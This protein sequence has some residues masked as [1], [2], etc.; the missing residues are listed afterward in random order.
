MYKKFHLENDINLISHHD[1]SAQTGQDIPHTPTYSR[2]SKVRS[3]LTRLNHQPKKFK[4]HQEF[5]HSDLKV[6]EY[7][8]KT[9]SVKNQTLR[10]LNIASEVVT[11]TKRLMPYGAGNQLFNIVST[12]GES[13]IRSY[14]SSYLF[15]QN[16]KPEEP[17]QQIKQIAERAIRFKAGNCD[18]M[19]AITFSLLTTQNLS[20]PILS[21]FDH[22]RDHFYTLIGDPKDP[23][24]GTKNTVVVDAWHPFGTVYTLRQAS[25]L[26]PEPDIFFQHPPSTPAPNS[27]ATLFGERPR[28]V[29]IAEIDLFAEKQGYPNVGDDLLEYFYE[30][31]PPEL[32]RDERVG[33]KDPSTIYKDNNGVSQTFDEIPIEFLQEQKSTLKTAD[34]FL[35][36]HPK[37]NF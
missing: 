24:W 23:T 2:V 3:T 18:A 29:H 35:E 28:T 30:T 11:K 19:E 22:D 31:S 6:N 13:A 37:W 21:A 17:I 25:I 27:I 1:L 34:T 20:A 32:C 10:H 7:Q 14:I 8:H 9:E 15:E 36:Q 16:P 26:N 4:L 12:K 5:T 33:T